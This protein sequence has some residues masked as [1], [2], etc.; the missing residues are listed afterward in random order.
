CEVIVDYFTDANLAVELKVLHLDGETESNGIVRQDEAVT[1]N[2]RPTV[3]KNLGVRNPGNSGSGPLDLPEEALHTSGY[4]VPFRAE[5]GARLGANAM[6]SALL[7]IANVLIHIAPLYLMCDPFVIR[8]Y[9]QVKSVH[10]K[11]PT[12]YF[13]DRYPGGIGLSERLFELHDELIEQAKELIRNCSC[14]SG[15]PACVGPI[16]E[17]GLLGKTQALQLLEET[18]GAS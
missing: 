4:S 11:R 7:G 14:L 10:M 18:G 16:E 15:C 8:V 1:V 17:V 3:I 6:Q 12:I 2:A 9:P 5:A 13:Y